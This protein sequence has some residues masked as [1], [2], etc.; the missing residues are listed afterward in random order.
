[1]TRLSIGRVLAA[2][3]VTILLAL[4]LAGPVLAQDVE[5]PDSTV[6]IQSNVDLLI[7]EGEQRDV[8]ILFR[9]DA[10]ILGEVET[11]VVF[12]GAA[13]LTGARVE[14]LVVA[15]GA[16]DIRGGSVVDEVRTIDS[17]YH[18]GTGAT[19]GS[20]QSIEPALIAAGLAPVAIAVWL[21]FALAFVLAG[22]LV[23]AIGGAQLRRAGAA[24]TAEPGP[25]TLAALAVLIGAPLVIVGLAVSLIGIPTAL[26]LAIVILPLV[27]FVGSVAVAVRI[28]DWILLR[29]RGRIEAQ[30]PLV[31]AFLGT[32]VV[33]ILSVI[34]LVGFLIGLAG[35]GAVLLI[36]TRAAFRSGTTTSAPTLEAGP[37]PA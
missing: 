28:G 7:P 20:Q 33:G 18:V 9:G 16:V 22:L 12:D 5:E 35:A 32:V 21:G 23:A 3:A 19:V 14:T 34:P 1:M 13:T 30:H 4:P 2:V 37:A 26:L 36:A 15:G 25:V 17:T 8:V 27:W 10:T 24:L 6:I 11:V 31:A 29:T